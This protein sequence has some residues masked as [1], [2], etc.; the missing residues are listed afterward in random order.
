[1]VVKFIWESSGDGGPA[2]PCLSLPLIR[3][4]D[5]VKSFF[6]DHGDVKRRSVRLRKFRMGTKSPHRKMRWLR[7]DRTR[8][9]DRACLL[10]FPAPGPAVLPAHRAMH[11]SRMGNLKG[12]LR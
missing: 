3:G 1:M 6:K 11:I 10:N 2:P 4:L 12:S 7:C 9:N 5:E 8:H